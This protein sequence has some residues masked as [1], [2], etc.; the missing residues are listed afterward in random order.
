MDKCHVAF[1]YIF[2]GKE[3]AMEN[4]YICD[5]IYDIGINCVT[6]LKILKC[7]GAK[8]N[9]TISYDA[10]RKADVLAFTFNDTAAGTTS[11]FN[12]KLINVEHEQV[13]IPE[14]EHASVNIIAAKDLQKVIADLATFAEDVTI[15]RRDNELAFRAT[16]ETA[17]GDTRIIIPETS[18]EQFQM[19]FALKYLVWFTKST[20]LCELVTLA[21]DDRY[22]MMVHIENDIVNMKFYLASKITEY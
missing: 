4:S 12:M 3:A 19:S 20:S 18:K 2:M 8:S 6:M 7:A 5:G 21:L 17:E 1:V 11:K 14:I 13:A 10:E 15:I 16:G 22:P 9:V